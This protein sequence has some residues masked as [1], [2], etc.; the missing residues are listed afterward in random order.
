M[1]SNTNIEDQDVELFK[2]ACFYIGKGSNSRKFSHINNLKLMKNTGY[3]PP[4]IVSKKILQ[5]HNKG[6]KVVTLQLHPE[7]CHYEAHSR[8]FA[9]IKAVGLKNVVNSYNGT[10]YGA[11]R[12]T[13][14]EK[15]VFNF[16][17][18]ILFHALT[19][20]VKDHPIGV[21]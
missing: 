18:M 2:H 13:W 7:V 17:T 16:G 20:C 11:M 15:E 3:L 5:L 21:M 9:I 14:S 12:H 8:E 4:T 1:I 6:I 10:P 19:M